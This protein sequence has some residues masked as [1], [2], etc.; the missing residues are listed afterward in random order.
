MSAEKNQTVSCSTFIRTST[1]GLKVISKSKF[2]RIY[3]GKEGMHQYANKIVET[4]EVYFVENNGEVISITRGFKSVMKFGP[5]GFIDEKHT[6]QE[7][8]KKM[9]KYDDYQV[10]EID[11]P[12]MIAPE[13]RDRIKHIL[14]L[15]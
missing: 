15:P 14:G 11:E 2:S 4:F 3:A 13:D 8:L 9:S 10:K 12:P 7:I 5:D 1:G 6:F